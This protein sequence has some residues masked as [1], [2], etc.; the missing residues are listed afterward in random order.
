M[1][2]LDWF[3]IGKEVVGQGMNLATQKLQY[4]REKKLM[5]IQM[6]NQMGLN[7]QAQE[8]SMKTWEATNYPAQVGML[9]QAGLNPSLLY[10]KG[11]AGGTT[12]SGTGG[13]AAMGHAPQ[14]RQMDIGALTQIE[15]MKS[16]AE[17]NK[18][19]AN[20]QNAQAEATRGYKAEE[21]A[22]GIE[23]MKAEAETERQKQALTKVQI[24]HQE[25]INSKTTEQLDA[26]INKLIQE[27]KDIE[28]KRKLTEAQFQDLVKLTA[29]QVIEA[30]VRIELGKAQT[31]LT[32]TNTVAVLNSI[33]Q[34]YMELAN[35]TRGLDQ[36]DIE[37]EI[38][39]ADQEIKLQYP[40]FGNV[41]GNVLRRALRMGQAW[42][43]FVY[44]KEME[45]Y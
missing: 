33:N 13:S 5:D 10:A 18:A 34:K 40:G 43:K 31:V 25:I 36:K 9:K 42:D 8:L 28:I 14:P 12:A 38:D 26:T 44:G 7:K 6:Q 11:G 39:K 35:Q 4:E 17:A 41:A 22:T 15:V 32:E 27:G 23:K 29:K 19:T 24:I 3:D 2:P 37:I 30:D 21:A 16:Q 1:A 20:N 45:K